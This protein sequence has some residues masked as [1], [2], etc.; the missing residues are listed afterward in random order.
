MSEACLY[1][2]NV[3]T[4][5][6][7][8]QGVKLVGHLIHRIL[9]GDVW[10][11]VLTGFWKRR[12]K[13]GGGGMGTNDNIYAQ[14]ILIL[15]DMQT[16]STSHPVYQVVM[17]L[18]LWTRSGQREEITIFWNLKLWSL[19]EFGNSLLHPSSSNQKTKANSFLRNVTSYGVTSQKSA[20]LT[21]TPVRT[22]TVT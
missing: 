5:L 6:L 10:D 8:W 1:M 2:H 4:S 7:P 22:S 3:L 17:K 11:E 20:M 19:V 12:G 15:G 9:N 21:I 13:G 16:Q 14:T 18:C